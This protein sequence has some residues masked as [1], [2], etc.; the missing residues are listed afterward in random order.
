[1][2]FYFLEET[3]L[4]LLNATRT[5]R[6]SHSETVPGTLTPSQ[7]RDRNVSGDAVEWI[8]PEVSRSDDIRDWARR[9]I[10]IREEA[11]TRERRVAR[12]STRRPTIDRTIRL[13]MPPLPPSVLAGP[14]VSL[15]HDPNRRSTG[16][17]RPK[18]I[19]YDL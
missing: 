8:A 5:R 17:K 1:M 12:P 10:A 13:T 11:E 14:S 9:M 3:F 19:I 2:F 7:R 16:G 18:Q 6:A 15:R 4:D